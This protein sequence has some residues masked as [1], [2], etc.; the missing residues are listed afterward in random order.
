M[1]P[2]AA[3][4]AVLLLVGFTLSAQ[5][6]VPLIGLSQPSDEPYDHG[7]EL[8]GHLVRG[9]THQHTWF[10]DEW[11]YTGV[12]SNFPDA[13]CDKPPVEITSG[14]IE[15][16]PVGLYSAFYIQFWLKANIVCP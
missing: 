13:E 12:V 16:D 3:L 2:H 6:P 5:S 4:A 7:C 9:S 8:T 11:D 1:L 10:R 15:R 14:S